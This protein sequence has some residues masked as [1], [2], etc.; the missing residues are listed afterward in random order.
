LIFIILKLL[1]LIIL[2]LVLSL[3]FKFILISLQEIFSFS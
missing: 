2:K 3:L 1:K